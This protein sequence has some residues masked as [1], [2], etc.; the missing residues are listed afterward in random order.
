MEAAQTESAGV[1]V[2]PARAP[3]ERG[4]LFQGEMVRA[5]LA[6]RKTQ[7]RRLVKLPRWL[8][9]RA[10]DME[11]AFPDRAF[12]VTPCLKVLY[13]EDGLIERVRN[14][15]GYPEPNGVRLWVRETWAA[16]WMYNDVPPRNARTEP[17]IPGDNRWYRADGEDAASHLGAP[18][19]GLRGKWRPARFM[20]R[21]A[22]RITLEVTDVRV[23]RLKE[24]TE[25]DARAE[26]L[27]E[28]RRDDSSPLHYGIA[29]P[30]VWETDPRKAYARLW[31]AI[32]GAGSWASNPWVWVVSFRRLAP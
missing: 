30:D 6:G 11:R 12:G 25:E 4:I 21:W 10:P 32:N 17:S 14:P 9:E 29:L 5:I 23:Q 18:S 13:G 7:T 28:W 20:P 16:H 15:W 24:I 27:T 3:K 1:A 22:S 26:G 8:S 31:D 2:A 19:A